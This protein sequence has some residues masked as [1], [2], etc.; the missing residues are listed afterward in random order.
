MTESNR[1]RT[2]REG[3]PAQAIDALRIIVEQHHVR[4]DQILGDSHLP[5]IAQARAAWWQVLRGLGYTTG[6]IGPMV[7]RDPSTVCACTNRLA[8]REAA[9]VVPP[10]PPS[11]RELVS[12]EAVAP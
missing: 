10:C 12:C 5:R 4:S 7:G 9:R 1:I 8:R 6:E 2:I 11:E 3:L